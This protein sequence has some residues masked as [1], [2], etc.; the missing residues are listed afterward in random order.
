M[1]LAGL[2][3]VLAT[4]LE[5]AVGNRSLLRLSSLPPVADNR[6]PMISVIVAARNEERNIRDG[7]NSLLAQDYPNV[8]FMVVNDR[9]SDQTG[10]I[11]DQ[12]AR[13]DRRVKAI[14]LTELPGG[15]LGKTHALHCGAQRATGEWLLFTDADVVMERS[16][17]GRAAGYVRST[18]IDHLAIAPLPQMPGTLLNMFGGAFALFRRGLPHLLAA[19]PWKA[20]DPKSPRHVGIGAFNLVRVGAYRAAG[21]HQAIAMRPDDDMKLGKLIKK[22]G[23]RQEIVLGDGLITV[24]WYSSVRELVRGLEKNTFAGMEYNLPMVALACAAQLAMFFWPF[25]ALVV[26]RGATFWIN[27]AIVGLL[28]LLYVD[29]A[30]FHRLKRWHC[31]GLPATALLFQY[32]IWRAT[33]KTLV[34]DGID[35]RG[36][37]YSLRELKAN[38]L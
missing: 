29:N 28:L 1:L 13:D 36:T 6:A 34:D 24:E 10:V 27:I 14:H 2:L 26:T 30:H 19:K 32:I 4:I 8:E 35:W 3:V 20:R 15:W 9:S 22:H 18:G 7:L 17:I 21:G 12:I 5:F 16:V 37:H 23:F 33:L 25:L 11:V 31:I 38:K